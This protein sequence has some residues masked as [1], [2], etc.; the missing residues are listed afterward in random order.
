VDVGA[1]A[2]IHALMGDLAAKGLAIMMISSELPEILALSDRVAVM[3]GGTITGT[4]DR[5][6]ATQERILDLA[7]GHR[8][9]V[10][11]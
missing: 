5:A 4:L 3:H 2:E 6:E 7:L 9:V 1:K 11:A 10:P 8:K